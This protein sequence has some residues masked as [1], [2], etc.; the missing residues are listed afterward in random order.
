M[1]EDPN[2]V[3]TVELSRELILREIDRLC[4]ILKER[5]V[6]TVL[7]EYGWGSNLDTSS[8]WQPQALQIDELPDFITA[9]EKT[10]IYR[11]GSADLAVRDAENE[12]TLLF[13]HESDIHLTTDNAGLRDSV[14]Q[15]WLDRGIAVRRR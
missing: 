7:V 15:G 12:F 14:M 13:C 2:E 8:L 5:N 1:A 9:A 11:A 10:G 3:V 4:E 6:T